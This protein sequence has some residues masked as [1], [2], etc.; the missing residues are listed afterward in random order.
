MIYILIFGIIILSFYFV[1]IAWIV[2]SL[3]KLFF[4]KSE[5]E[6]FPKK[7]SILVAV[8]N[9]EENISQFIKQILNQSYKFFEIIIVDDHSIDNTLISLKKIHDEKLFVFSLPEGR[10][11]KKEALKYGLNFVT[12]E[13][14][15]F[16][17]ADVCVEEDW[18]ESYIPFTNSEALVVAPV[19]IQTSK[20]NFF[21]L[22]QQ[23]DFAAMQYITI[24][25]VFAKNPFICNGANMALGTK[26]AKHIY[27][28][29]NTAIPSGDDVFVLHEHL[30]NKGQVRLNFSPSSIAFIKP[31]KTLSEFIV[32]RLR[33]AS[34]AKYY[35]N[36]MAILV[37]LIIFISNFYILILFISSFYVHST[38]IALSLFFLVKLIIEF[39]LFYVGNKI[40]ALNRNWFLFFPFISLIYFLYISIVGI[41]SV[42]M[43]ISWK[44]RKWK[45]K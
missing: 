16:T 7:I 19:F 24:A 14:V 26:T 10:H 5:Q 4:Y 22:F 17:D 37:S 9:E 45:N 12:G 2:F 11:G 44:K 13:W 15:V 39:T 38:L 34:K 18:L 30:R 33:W 43:P 3:V 6:I 32:Q 42:F 36:T 25:S 1:F 40:I 31:N 35:K 27:S 21:Q 41:S 29:L 20:N 23:L 28:N 8:R